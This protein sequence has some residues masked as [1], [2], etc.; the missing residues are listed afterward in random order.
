MKNFKKSFTGSRMSYDALEVRSISIIQSAERDII[1]LSIMGVTPELL[2]KLK[3]MLTVMRAMDK[4]KVLISY[5][6]LGTTE[7][8]ETIANLKVEYK[9]IVSQ[10]FLIFSADNDEHKAIMN[11]GVSKLK[12]TQLLAAASNLLSVI[13]EPTQDMIAYGVTSER[14]ASFEALILKLIIDASFHEIGTEGLRIETS[15]RNE[16]KLEIAK[17]LEFISRVGKAYWT[18]ANKPYYDSYVIQKLKM[19]SSQEASASDGNSASPA[20]PLNTEG[21]E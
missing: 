6:A 12:P 14:I 18:R 13:K 15:K 1:Y 9:R 5:K 3:E 16:L 4:H 7:R 17:T 11:L 8:N 19:P 20:E 2:T 10:L 21:E